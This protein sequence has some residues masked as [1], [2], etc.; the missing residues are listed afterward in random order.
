MDPTPTMPEA[1]HVAVS[2]FDAAEEL[3][4]EIEAIL[5]DAPAANQTVIAIQKT[6]TA[7]LDTLRSRCG[8]QR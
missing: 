1:L 8:G 3:A 5:A 6:I 2:Q 7:K 4:V